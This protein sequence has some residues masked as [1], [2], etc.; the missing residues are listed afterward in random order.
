MAIHLVVREPFGD[1]PKGAK[2]TDP[3]EVEALLA[4]KGAHVIKVSAPDA[5]EEP[6]PA[7]EH[8]EA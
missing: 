1:Y 3:A 8:P 7:P 6:T 5:G 2:I 4:D